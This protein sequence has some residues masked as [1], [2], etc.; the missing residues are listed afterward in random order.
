MRLVLEAAGLSVG[1]QPGC[2]VLRDISFSLAAGEL[3]GIIG[4]SGCGKSTLCQALAGIIPRQLP[5]EVKGKIL[6]L[7]RNLAALSLPEIAADLGI[8]FQD[9][10]TQLFLPRVRNELAFGPENLCLP[11]EEIGM[12]IERI[13][14]ELGCQDLLEANPNQ[15]SGGQQQLIAL[16]AVLALEPKL[17]ILD[18]VTAQ[19]DPQT[20]ARLQAIIGGLRRRGMAVL[21]VEH[22]LAQLAAADRIFALRNGQL[23]EAAAAD[24]VDDEALRRVYG[25]GRE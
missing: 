11:R 6:L 24:L 2:W 12:R 16:A 19:L 17:L 20:C 8:V 21:M 7:G 14:E 22:N 3:V 23:A 10:E 15:L 4:P 25:G 13:A 18:E 1:W 9:P 5:G